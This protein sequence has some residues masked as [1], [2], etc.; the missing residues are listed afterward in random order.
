MSDE[1]QAHAEGESPGA[2]LG[3]QRSRRRRKIG[4]IVGGVAAAA[5]VAVGATVA[6]TAASGGSTPS[7][8]DTVVKA[9]ISI[10]ISWDP[11]SAN[12][13]ASPGAIAWVYDS[14]IHQSIDRTFSPGLAESWEWSDDNLA[15]SFTLREGLTFSDGADFDADAV[16]TYFDRVLEESPY[17]LPKVASVE[18]VDDTNVVFHLSQPNFQLEAVLASNTK[19]A[20]IPSPNTE[21]ADLATTPV[22]N[23][24][25]VVDEILPDDHI[26]LKKNPDYWAADQIH[27]DTLELYAQGD[28]TSIVS[29]VKT[30]VYDL[31]WI[32]PSQ[33]EEA[34]G[35][36]LNLVEAAKQVVSLQFNANIEPFTNPRVIEA[37]KYAV[38]RDEA[39]E[40]LSLGEG[41][42]AYQ[43]VPK[44]SPDYQ[45]DLVGEWEY[46]PEKAKEILAAEGYSDAS[47]LS[48]TYY[49][50][51]ADTE[52]AEFFA[53]QFAEVGMKVDIQTVPASQAFQ[54]LVAGKEATAS[55][56][57]GPIPRTA[58]D[59]RN[60][61][62]PSGV[63]NVNA[64]KPGEAFADYVA[65]GGY[66]NEEA[67]AIIDGE[68]PGI[69]IYSDEYY[70]KLKELYAVLVKTYPSLNLYEAPHFLATNERT[71]DVEVSVVASY[72][73]TLRWEGVEIH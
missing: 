16:K 52:T 43:P 27:V 18:A 24:P 72:G 26:V 68:L 20:F 38:D 21:A 40:A 58:N 64:A 29:Q 66:V 14:L 22:G 53:Q 15:L 44:G 55:I 46:D 6:A 25:F 51:E 10:P 62:G 48:F 71:K 63:I 9:A 35:A 54:K 5:V 1:K 73:P 34:R 3:Q 69:P 49:V 61:F 8:E 42:P 56:A 31:A 17:F 7:A 50:S 12:S 57:F 19:V 67:L 65:R 39:V 37:L 2:S 30:G 32:Q 36:G 4:L 60:I 23:G 41:V 33:A 11:A 13:T 28:P 59:L 47:P 70:A 45:E